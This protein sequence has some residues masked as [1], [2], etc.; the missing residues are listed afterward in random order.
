MLFN[1]SIFN[2]VVETAKAKCANSPALLRAIDRAVYEINRSRYWAFDNTSNTLRIQ[3]T[4]KRKLYVV[5]DHHTCEATEDGSKHCRHRVARRLMQRYTEACAASGVVCE[6]S[7]IQNWSTSEGHTVCESERV[8]HTPASS[9]LSEADAATFV[10][11]T[12]KGEK[13]D[14]VDI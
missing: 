9:R 4:S 14:G 7:R 12:L 2:S 13:Y 8:T 6:R 3:Y 5:D 1:I 11:R 10:P